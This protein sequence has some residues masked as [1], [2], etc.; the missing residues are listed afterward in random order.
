MRQVKR[1]ALGIVVVMTL[2][3]PLAHAAQNDF[4]IDLKELGPAKPKAKPQLQQKPQSSPTTTGEISLKELRRIAPPRPAK[5]AQHKHR[6]RVAAEAENAKATKSGNESI[7]VVKPGEHLFLILMKQYGLSNAAAER[8]IPEVMQLNGISSPK[9]LK[10]GQRLRIPLPAKE[11]RD[12]ASRTS[13][14]TEPLPTTP[15]AAE[16]ATQTQPP[17]PALTPAP[18]QAQTPLQVPTPVQASAQTPAPKPDAHAT[19]ADA[20]SIVSA[21]PCKLARDLADKMGLLATAPTGILG[22]ETVGA[23]HAG[24]VITVA[25]GLSEAE[26]YTYERL[27]ARSGKLLLVFDGDES[28]ENVV[29]E[30]ASSL[31]LEFHKGEAVA[32]EQRPTYVFAPFGVRTQELQLTIL[33]AQTPPAPPA[34]SS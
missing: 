21:P 27:L 3:P 28:A 2:I 13:A 8:L 15:A 25:C 10:A 6:S 4:D 11:G 16:A 22:T 24:R 1:I 12:S 30:L 33:P 5:P 18:T 14:T 17:A 19:V 26:Q 9:G 7:Y 29:E 32:T 34:T 31:G 23:V 20:I